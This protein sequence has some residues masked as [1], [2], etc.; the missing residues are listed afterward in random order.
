MTIPITVSTFFTNVDNSIYIAL[1]IG[2]T[3]ALPGQFPYQASLRST[4]NRHFCGGSIYTNRWIIS[5]AHCT[6]SKTPASLKVAVG[7]NSIT[8]GVSYNVILIKNHPSFNLRKYA[9]DVSLVKTAVA[10][11]FN[12]IVAPIPL[13]TANIQGV[14][15]CIASGWGRTSV[16]SAE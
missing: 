10:I 7:T 2:G 1:I 3:T 13:S 12:S 5:A 4:A 6:E 15:N 9:N 14:V 16:V 8:A 11:T